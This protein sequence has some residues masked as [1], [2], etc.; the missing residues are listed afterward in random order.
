MSKMPSGLQTLFPLRFAAALTVS[1]TPSLTKVNRTLSKVDLQLRSAITSLC[2]QYQNAN[3]ADFNLNNNLW[4]ESSASSGSQ[5]TYLD[6]DS[7]D[8]ISWQTSWIWQGDGFSV[9]SYSNAVLNA[10]VTKLSSITSMPSTWK[11]S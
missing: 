5:C 10:P 3:A 1:G 8:T 2:G 6:Y 11:W 7:G 9:K 4:A